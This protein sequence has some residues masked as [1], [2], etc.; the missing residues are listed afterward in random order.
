MPQPQLLLDFGQA[1]E[2][3]KSGVQVSRLGWNGRGMY[4]YRRT[5]AGCEP[6]LCL[7]TA[8]GA[9]QPGWLPSQADLFATDWDRH[10]P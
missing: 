1:L 8:Q 10:E 7:H 6:S 4:V 5:F 9:E 2:L 3:L